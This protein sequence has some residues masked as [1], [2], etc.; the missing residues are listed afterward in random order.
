NK[1][2]QDKFSAQPCTQF[3]INLIHC[4]VHK[5]SGTIMEHVCHKFFEGL[6]VHKQIKAD[7]KNSKYRKY[8]TK[9]V[10]C[11]V[12][13]VTAYSTSLTGEIICDLLL[14]D[15]KTKIFK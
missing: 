5:F 14:I 13:G 2:H 10:S 1:D 4:A 15:R 7:D 9:N 8:A 11:N 6:M 3:L 12:D